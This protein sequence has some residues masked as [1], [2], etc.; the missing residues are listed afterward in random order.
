MRILIVNTSERMGGSAIAAG[1]LKEA[2]KLHGLKVRMLVRDKETRK[3]DVVALRRSWLL[4]WK[5][6]WERIVIWA[7]NKFH[8]HNLFAVDI[9]SQGTDITSLPEFQ[10]ADIIHLHWINQGFLSLKNLRKIAQCGKPI[11]WTMHDMWPCTGICHY[12]RKC[13]AYHQHCGTC[14]YLYHRGWKKDISYQI[15]AK[16]RV[17]YKDAPLTF[18]TCSR[19]LEKKAQESPLLQGKTIQ[20]IPNPINTHLFKPLDKQEAR[21]KLKLPLDRIYILFGPAKISHRRKGFDQL[22]AASKILFTQFPEYQSKLGIITLGSQSRQMQEHLPFQVFPMDWENNEEDL[23]TIYNAADLYILPSLEENLPNSLMEAMSCGVPCVGYQVGGVPEM[24]DHK[25]NGYVAQYKSVKDL[26]QGIHWVL[27]AS[28]YPA[29]SA[30]AVRKVK[31]HYSE[32]SVAHR[33]IQLYTQLLK[34]NG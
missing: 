29:L 8:K 34:N 31:N 17:L 20:S 2:L 3:T 23:I 10:E 19:W 6:V 14:M 26:A 9:A 24:I 21:I 4:V 22:S 13:T 18:V 12:A 33:Y 7:A 32:T 16:K 25:R 11:V 27:S 5:F 30:D 28:D 15:F 1:R